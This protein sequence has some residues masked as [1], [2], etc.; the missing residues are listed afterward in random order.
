MNITVWLL[1]WF[2][3]SHYYSVATLGQFPSEAECR[4][5]A[6]AIWS[7]RTNSDQ[8]HYNVRENV[9]VQATIVKN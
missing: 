5:V 8:P 9:C 7:Q 2:S 4:R 6:K 3:A 1:V